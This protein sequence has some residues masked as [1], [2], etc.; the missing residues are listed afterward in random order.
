ME[1]SIVGSQNSTVVALVCV[2]STRFSPKKICPSEIKSR[3]S[4]AP[5]LPMYQLPRIELEGTGVQAS[6]LGS[7]DLSLSLLLVRE[8]PRSWHPCPPGLPG[9]LGSAH[10]GALVE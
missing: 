8:G 7:V 6:P 2:V 3:Q 10:V 4:I 1:Q 5:R 9:L